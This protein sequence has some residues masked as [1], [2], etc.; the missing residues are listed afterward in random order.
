MK[1]KSARLGDGGRELA[2]GN[3]AH[4]GEQDRMGDAEKAGE[5]RRDRHRHSA[6][7]SGRGMFDMLSEIWRASASAAEFERPGLLHDAD[8]EASRASG[9]RPFGENAH[10]R[11]HAQFGHRA[12]REPARHRGIDRVRI[13]TRIGD[14]EFAARPSRAR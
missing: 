10:A 1:P 13:G 2:A 7:I 8:I 14:A 9:S 6:A 12:D 5:R 3:P 4:R 11:S